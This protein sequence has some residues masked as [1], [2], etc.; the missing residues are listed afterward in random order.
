[1]IEITEWTRGTGTIPAVDGRKLYQ[2]L[3]PGRDFSTWITAKVKQLGYVE[4]QD[5]T[6]YL[7][8]QGNSQPTRE[9][10][11]CLQMACELCLLDRSETG[12]KL[13][14]F[15]IGKMESPCKG[16]CT[17]SG[18]VLTE[19]APMWDLSADEL[20]PASAPTLKA[21]PKCLR[22]HVE[23]TAEC[24]KCLGMTLEAERKTALRDQRNHPVV[25][26]NPWIECLIP[27]DG[28]TTTTVPPF[29]TVVTF[30]RNAAGRAIAKVERP[31]HRSALLRSAFYRSYTE[32]EE[33]A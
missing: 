30:K 13:R 10:T 8:E 14:R 17:C 18:S 2:L 33:A 15:I 16:E 19:E 22:P 7:V 4:G 28:D 12:R 25:T 29:G 23:E 26:A 3:N 20:K 24:G 27:R 6:S 1:M 31:E 32:Q 9:Y 5:F 21:C 11:L